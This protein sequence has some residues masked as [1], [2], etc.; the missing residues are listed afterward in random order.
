MVAP[1]SSDTSNGLVATFALVPLAR[2]RNEPQ[3]DSQGGR[4]LCVAS[5][6]SLRAPVCGAYSLK[7]AGMLRRCV[8]KTIAATWTLSQEN[9]ATYAYGAITALL[10]VLLLFYPSKQAGYC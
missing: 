5:H 8:V 1:G 9:A 4:L 3:L 6:T 2:L 10:L 7:Y